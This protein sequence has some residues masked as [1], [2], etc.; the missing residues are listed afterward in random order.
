MRFIGFSV[1]TSNSFVGTELLKLLAD[2]FTTFV[3]PGH[4]NLSPNLVLSKCFELLE[5]D[6]CI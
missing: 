6:Q 5:S 2:E 3:I 4:L 1:L